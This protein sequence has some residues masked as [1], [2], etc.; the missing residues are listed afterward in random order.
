M[1]MEDRS[2]RD[3][4][5]LKDAVRRHWQAEPCGTRDASPGERRRFF[6]EIERDRYAW[7]PYI[8]PFARFERGRGK[9]VLEVGVGAG[10]DF[11]QWA[12]AG[13]RA[14][15]IDL[16]QEAIDHARARLDV[17]GLEAADLR[18]GDC[19]SLPYEDDSFD[20]V[21]SWGVIHHTG[22]MWEALDRLCGAVNPGGQLY[23]A[24]YNDQGRAS[25]LWR[26]VKRAY[27]RFPVL[28]PVV[29]AYTWLKMDVWGNL[30]L[31]HPLRTF[32]REQ[33]RGMNHWHDLVDWAGGY[34]FEVATIGEVLDFCQARGF[35]LEWLNDAGAGH[36][37]N[38]FVFRRA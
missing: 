15:G 30:S 6:D 12:R 22:R 37:C 32:T 29:L 8:K 20:L 16:T 28:R 33:T 4:A 21:Y 2:D 3:P 24:I 18:K 13:A 14:H 17:Y 10:T 38:E 7:E 27:A 34:P 31:S 1:S 25:K 9:R 36:G 35:R 26:V 23:I 19:E 11:I 5:D